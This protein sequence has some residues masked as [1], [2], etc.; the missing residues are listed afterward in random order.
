MMKKNREEIYHF[1][2]DKPF[3]N[4]KVKEVFNDI[5]QN[6][7]WHISEKRESVSGIGSSLEQ[8]K[9]IIKVLPFVLKKYKINSILDIPCGDFNWMQNIDFSKTKYIGGDIV[10]EIIIA[11]NGKHKPENINFTELNLIED[12]LPKVDLIFCRDCLVHLSFKDILD[13]IE[14]IKAS[15]SRYLMTTTF[16]EQSSNKDINTGGW[17]PLNLEL[18]PFHFP[19]PVYLLNEKCMEMDGLFKDKSLGLWE[20]ENL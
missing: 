15:G 14:N 2:D 11:N 7:L 16:T 1:S 17:R 4:K 6:N 20:I 10:S 3:E 8:T 9:E 5:Y 19:K 13:S 18:E 12:R